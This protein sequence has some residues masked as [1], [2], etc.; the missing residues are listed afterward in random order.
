LIVNIDLGDLRS[1]VEM[2]TDVFFDDCADAS[3]YPEGYYAGVEHAIE[4]AQEY[5][6]LQM[7]EA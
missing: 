4:K 6:R 3:A 7:M 2:E 5:V 1:F